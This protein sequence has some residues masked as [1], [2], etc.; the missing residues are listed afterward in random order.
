MPMRR[1]ACLIGIAMVMATGAFA[2]PL[3]GSCPLS[4]AQ[5]D[6]AMKAFA[7]M[8]PVLQHPRCINCHGVFA[9]LKT[10]PDTKHP[11]KQIGPNESCTDCHEQAG[12]VWEIPPPELF[13]TAR[14]D[15]DLCTQFKLKRTGQRFFDH[16][17]KDPRILLGFEGKRGQDLE[18]KPPPVS[19][20]DFVKMA[21]D[22]LT[23][24]YGTD[25]PKAWEDEFPGGS[26][27]KCGCESVSKGTVSYDQ[28][29]VAAI[30]H[31]ADAS[32]K[33]TPDQ[34]TDE[35]AAN[36]MSTDEDTPRSYRLDFGKQTQ[37]G[38]ERGV[39]EIE[40]SE[41]EP[42][43]PEGFV[44]HHADAA[45]GVTTWVQRA[46]AHDAAGKE[47]P[48]VGIVE[49][50]ALKSFKE[51]QASVCRRKPFNG[52]EG[53]ADTAT[54]EV[55]R[56]VEEKLRTLI[57]T[58][59]R[60]DLFAEKEEKKEEFWEWYVRFSEL[61][62]E[63]RTKTDQ[64]YSVADGIGERL[65][66]LKRSNKILLGSAYVDGN[67]RNDPLAQRMLERASDQSREIRDYGIQ[68][69]DATADIKNA[70]AKVDAELDG[71][72]KKFA[73]E[74]GEEL[75][76][77]RR[78]FRDLSQR[79]PLDMALA[80][81]DPDAMRR[82]AEEADR[83]GLSVKARL[84]Q[85]QIYRANGDVVAALYAIRQ[86]V[87][88]D[89]NSG[90]AKLR[91]AE[92]ECA[93]LQV[94]LEKSQ[95]AIRDARN[96][97]Y[98][99]LMERGFAAKDNAAGEN[100]WYSMFT[101]PN[102]WDAETAWAVFT[103]GLFG[104]FSSY[105]DK[106]G[107]EADMLATDETRLTVAYMGLQ[108][109]L[110]LRM[111]GHSLTEI[112]DMTSDQLLHWL[113]L[114]NTRGEDYT[115]TQAANLRVAINQAM[116]L[117]DVQA[118]V[119]DDRTSL[120]LGINESYWNAEDVGN[121]WIEY[122]GDITSVQNVLLIFLPG[123][124]VG[125]APSFIIWGKEELAAIAAA[126]KA[127]QVMS[128]TEA[129]VRM[130]RLDRALTAL[131]SA[132]G[133]RRLLGI[134]ERMQ[135]FDRTF[136]A[137]GERA[138]AFMRA[139]GV[140]NTVGWTGGKFMG[141]LIIQGLAIHGAEELAGHKAALAMQAALFFANDSALFIKLL[142]GANIPPQQVE[143]LLVTKFLPAVEEHSKLNALVTRTCDD[144]E[145]FWKRQPTTREG[146]V[147]LTDEAFS[148]LK[149]LKGPGWS[150][151]PVPNGQPGNDII[152]PMM[153]SVADA[154]VKG[155]AK[156][157]AADALRAM[158]PRLLAEAQQVAAAGKNAT[159]LIQKLQAATVDA[160]I[161]VNPRPRTQLDIKRA[162]A[163]WGDYALPPA[164]RPGSRCAEAEA[165]L[166]AKDFKGALEIYQNVRR[167]ILDGRARE[168]EELPLEFLQLKIS[169][170]SEGLDAKRPLLEAGPTSAGRPVTKD[171]VAA[172]MTG[173]DAWK[174]V[175]KERSISA[176]FYEADVGGQGY[177]IKEVT[178]EGRA[179]GLLEQ[180]EGEIVH[181]DLASA[182]GMD[183]PGVDAKV[184]TKPGPNPGRVVAGNPP[185]GPVV[186]PQ[187]ERIWVV[188]DAN[189][190]YSVS[191]DNDSIFVKRGTEIQEFSRTNRSLDQNIERGYVLASGAKD[192]AGV[193]LGLDEMKGK[194]VLD[195]AS[196]T[197][198]AT[199][200]DL[201]R[202]GIDADGM[203]IAL[204]PGKAGTGL[205]QADITNGVPFADG[206]YDVVY[207]FFGGLSYG[208]GDQSPK[209]LR[210]A[211][212]KV[213]PGG[214]VYLSPVDAK[215]LANMQP[216]LDRLTAQGYK[217]LRSDYGYGDS[218][219]RIVKPAEATSLG[220]AVTDGRVGGGGV[221]IPPGGGAE[222]GGNVGG[223][224]APG[225]EVSITPNKDN[226][227]KLYLIY[228]RIE[229]Q[230]LSELTAG[231]IFLHKEELARHRVLSIL[232]NDY[233]RKIDN[234]FVGADGRLYAID[235]AWADVRGEVAAMDGI[236][237]DAP[238]YMEGANGRDHWLSRFYKDEP[239][240]GRGT[241]VTEL[242]KPEKA[243]SRKGLV[244]EE[245][246]TYADAKPA[247]DKVLQ[248][249]NDEPKLRE[250][251]TGSFTKIYGNDAAKVQECVDQCVKTLQQR[252][253]RL[254]E[255]LRGLDE[256]NITR[257]PSQG[258]MLLGP[259][260]GLHPQSVRRFAQR[261]V[262]F[263]DDVV[264]RKAA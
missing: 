158:R 261:Q 97:F 65:P 8:K 186:V 113:P 254:E 205:R 17:K 256:R 182:L 21:K 143:K 24:L 53:V 241:P 236:P 59:T 249:V 167:L 67:L 13:F 153:Q 57:E 74:H 58:G 172:V 18:P 210:S 127:G 123:V 255:V 76:E 44:Q 135:E 258:S 115:P 30:I 72:Y 196:G 176:G 201:R 222:G 52:A 162:P 146:T 247:L 16:I 23:A 144:L 194:K 31:A 15:T 140:L 55:S 193:K 39:Y 46:P 263:A 51:E 36:Y 38:D 118:L 213:K 99:Y 47:I 161:I 150:P 83:Q 109:I 192:P 152:V 250:I 216:E 49:A 94:A 41:K 82:A 12:D 50:C 103:T 35:I 84:I 232:L 88:D 173:R 235:A 112:R 230:P 183:A 155:K 108:A 159:T 149:R 218:I 154:A 138:P 4:P 105:F 33:L 262:P 95:G 209:A 246:L 43:P 221:P 100:T 63:T 227:E 75:L 19:H 238:F 85:A 137:V 181:S 117:P 111:R 69:E 169:L 77:W 177:F 188:G 11:G 7:A 93:F 157:G 28:R 179:G 34:V 252:A 79:L 257:P 180:A 2:K 128:G 219:L 10:N 189:A 224:T 190:S 233:D 9:D 42:E 90:E 148:E 156:S 253:K 202:A 223:L 132:D 145:A 1:I 37:F 60:Y 114:K 68:L 70:Y 71:A 184:V 185:S 168:T 54:T 131:K 124:K 98:G 204:A 81:S 110:R 25:E 242:W 40:K 206:N 91:L 133:E 22:W 165:K 89:P 245:A 151:K 102:Q 211:I 45:T 87:A 240:L 6:K 119:K 106:P 199:V 234:Y 170:A 130:V 104:S 203:D 14:S 64:A 136:G 259:L 32:A 191:F 96:A 195:L 56:D 66:I 5:A 26:E 215:A 171:D 264:L 129:V 248:L 178:R 260:P 214:F 27:T 197:D 78:D 198:A 217:V 122:L 92:A 231:Q 228:R 3:E 120:Q 121:T 125:A 220:G 20:D 48:G 62:E 107:A 80:S 141:A 147:I 239:A 163:A 229:G 101:N 116:K 243:F 207:E 134:L 226:V 244:A 164:P 187:G 251:L 175:T 174:P 225:T 139:V 73:K 29:A 160:P 61:L 212:D 200:Q 126:E 208:L 86:A 142:R 166:Q 237:P